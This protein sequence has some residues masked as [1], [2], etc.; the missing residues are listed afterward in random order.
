M[1]NPEISVSQRLF[2]NIYNILLVIVNK[3]LLLPAIDVTILHNCII[4]T[5]T[6]GLRLSFA[7]TPRLS[8]CYLRHHDVM[9]VSL[10]SL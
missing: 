4:G 6:S 1:A 8:S 3:F 5:A 10:A 9:L 7:S 2:G